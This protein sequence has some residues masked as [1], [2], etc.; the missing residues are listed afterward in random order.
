MRGTKQLMKY[1][2][3]SSKKHKI[4]ALEVDAIDGG[5]HWQFAAEFV[6]N[7]SEYGAMNSE[8]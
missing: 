7:D 8:A 4:A 1:H 5:K 2:F 3:E 6:V